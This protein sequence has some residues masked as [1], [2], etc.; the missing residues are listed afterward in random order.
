MLL[1]SI[2]I[3]YFIAQGKLSFY[4]HDLSQYHNYLGEWLYYWYE[5]TMED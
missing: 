2:T 1:N 5:F 4:F 3:E